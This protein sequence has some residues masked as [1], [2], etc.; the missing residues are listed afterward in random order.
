MI[1]CIIHGCAHE[2]NRIF[3][4]S[5]GVSGYSSLN[6]L[7]QTLPNLIRLKTAVEVNTRVFYDSSFCVNLHCKQKHLG[8][9]NINVIYTVINISTNYKRVIILFLVDGNKVI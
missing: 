4:H 3:K 6:L 7:Y 1:F 9:S 8:V 2:M 5:K